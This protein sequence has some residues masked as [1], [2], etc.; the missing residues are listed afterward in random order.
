MTRPKTQQEVADFHWRMARDEAET[1]PCRSPGCGADVGEHC[2][3]PIT[4][5]ELAGPAHW[6]R[7]RDARQG[8]GS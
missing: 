7:V 8:D 5:E 3:N 4:G 6:Q 1:V 2:Q